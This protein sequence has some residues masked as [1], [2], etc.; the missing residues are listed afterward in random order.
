MMTDTTDINEYL[1]THIRTVPDWPKPGV[2]FRDVSTL[3]ENP[4][5]WRKTLDS[6]V[7]RYMEYDID[8]IGTLDARGFLIGS[9]LAYSLNLPLVMF[10]KKGKLP[11][12]TL[13]Q[14]YDLEYGTA[15]LEVHSDTIKPADKIL[16]VDD[17]IATGGTLLAAHQL[18]QKAGATTVE[19]AAIID[20]PDLKGAEKLK[21]AGI[22][23]F[24]LC[25]FEGE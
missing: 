13:S 12:D 24:C 23:T 3:F 18:I 22:T 21:A 14:E 15:T 1:K 7:H 10:R 8:R 5:A 17:L 11:F 9:A 25:Q 2:M 16:L 19:A 6:L 20:L 4:K